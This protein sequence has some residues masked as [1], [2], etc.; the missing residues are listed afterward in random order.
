MQ[1]RL[2][3]ISLLRSIDLLSRS[4]DHPPEE[5]PAFKSHQDQLKSVL[6]VLMIIA[7]A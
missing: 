6:L 3:L 7:A 5:S 2:W 1:V 4:Q